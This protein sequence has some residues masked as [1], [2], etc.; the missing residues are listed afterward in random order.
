MGCDGTV[1]YVSP[2]LKRVLGHAP[3][4]RTN[5]N[6]IE[7]IHPDD[8]ARARDLLAEGS[9]KPGVPVSAEL[10]MRHADGSWCDSR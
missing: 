6:A 8:V 3:E 9:R 4:D 7:P 2:A 5:A 1:R 10:R